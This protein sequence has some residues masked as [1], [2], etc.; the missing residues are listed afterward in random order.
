[1]TTTA[2]RDRIEAVHAAAHAPGDDC[3]AG[4]CLTPELAALLTAERAA[5]A[6]N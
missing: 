3:D 2:I 1:M 6:A 5:L 4:E